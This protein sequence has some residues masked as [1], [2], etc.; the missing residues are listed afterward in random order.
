MADQSQV[1]IDASRAPSAP[2][3]PRAPSPPSS[4]PPP[5]PAT[6]AAAAA[7]ATPG[8]AAPPAPA[9]VLPLPPQAPI[10][11]FKNGG[12]AA[13][14]AGAVVAPAATTLAAAGLGHHHNHQLYTPSGRKRKQ[15]TSGVWKYFEQFTPVAPKGR[16]VRCTIMV[17][18]PP[19][20]ALG[21][22]QRQVMCG[23]SY[24]HV[25]SSPGNGGS[26]TSGMLHHLFKKH[27]LIHAEIMKA[28]PSNKA[29]RLEGTEAKSKDSDDG[30]D[31][32]QPSSPSTAMGP[33][34]PRASRAAE[35]AAGPMTAEDSFPHDRRFVLMCA[36]QTLDP[37]SLDSSL[38]FRLFLDKLSPRLASWKRKGQ[39]SAATTRA[40]GI[41]WDL[42]AG[43]RRG[44]V[45]KLKAQSESCRRLGWTGPFV[46]L[47]VDSTGMAGLGGGGDE[48]VCT[49]SVSFVPEDFGGLVRLAIGAR[50]FH[51]GE[52]SHA[53]KEAW[54][55]E[56]TSDLFSCIRG[57]PAPKDIYL[58][59]TVGGRSG[60]GG[61]GGNGF[62]RALE[63]MG[64]P[65]LVCSS[66]RLHAAVACSLGADSGIGS[67]G[68]GG[69]PK[70]ACA[71]GKMRRVVRKA[72][73]MAEKFERWRPAGGV[74][75]AAVAAA[76]C[77][78]TLASVRE[79]VEELGVALARARSS[80]ARWT[81]SHA[82]FER[83]LQLAGPIDAY[84][85]ANPS[86]N[87]LLQSEWQAIREAAS[88]LEPALEVVA[89]VHP[90][91]EGDEGGGGR[92]VA[93]AGPESEAPGVNG[94]QAYGRGGAGGQETGAPTAASKK[95]PREVSLSESIELHANL[96]CSFIYPLQDIRSGGGPSDDGV[97]SAAAAAGAGAAA[98]GEGAAADAALLAPVGGG[99]EGSLCSKR[100][101]NL[102]P[103]A[104]ALLGAVAQDME[105]SGLGRARED[106][107]AAAMLLDPR[108]KQ[109]CA[110]TCVD[111]G[112]A[113]KL[114][115]LTA[116][117]SQLRKF[118]GAAEAAGAGNGAAPHAQNQQDGGGGV[119]VV[120]RLEK[121]R[122]AQKMEAVAAAT[123]GGMGG[124]GAATT[125]AAAAVGGAYGAG[126]EGHRVVEDAL[127]ELGEYMLEPA[128]KRHEL[129]PYWKLNGTDTRDS[130]TGLVVL[131]A[132]WPHLAL[133]A[134]LYAGIDSTSRQGE[135]HFGDGTNIGVAVSLLQ[136]SGM[137]PWR[138]E[139]MLIVRLNQ[140][141]VPEVSD[142]HGG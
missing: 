1:G 103:E 78:T 88:I 37:A 99:G 107:E 13:V 40:N 130:G 69:S 114:R 128:G 129:L 101:E 5:S 81:D 139:E 68:G 98:G 16:N 84:F 73:S 61:D 54:I 83:L 39:P 138:I 96:H 27:P 70:E 123:G 10:D 86:S 41:L 97:G 55:R 12:A 71:N 65:V 17:D 105:E 42:C 8:P 120:S 113:L 104:Q 32:S 125:A 137:P 95:K 45:A 66:Y 25:E 14:V 121:M 7:A 74:Y 35:A 52:E 58:A 92:A 6:A 102:T 133:L 15:R 23:A 124:G 118:K 3:P 75:A 100:V 116:V 79:E 72:V 48:E 36:L 9:G 89:K 44:V 134:R 87:S 122:Q 4:Q 18:V 31:S 59:A 47:Q 34:S 108:F 119:A 29:R 53:A 22:P 109:C 106:T 21:L 64:V 11:A 49:A 85:R 142:F 26:G 126:G 140:H 67:G 46:A 63:T 127:A 115:A 91:E 2:A 82:L 141:L 80:N 112:N 93:A 28:N 56:L 136:W 43:V 111:G 50:C 90:A 38:G 62:R 51:G 24:T 76:A 20:P 57:D 135:R 33:P 94:A 77:P 131:A 19:D 30:K 60:G 117:S 132:R 110:S